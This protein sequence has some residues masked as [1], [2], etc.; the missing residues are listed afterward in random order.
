MAD[1]ARSTV[2][3]PCSILVR[4]SSSLFAASLSRFSMLIPQVPELANLK[5]DAERL[6]E[7]RA[8]YG[9]DKPVHE[10]FFEMIGNYLTFDFGDSYFHD[11]SVIDLVISKLPV[12][13]RIRGIHRV[14]MS[15][16]TAMAMRRE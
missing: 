14:D 13:I 11:K 6:Q 4:I 9:F 8:L 3:N 10:R 5:L 12:S 15:F 2:P 16:E 7:I 1:V